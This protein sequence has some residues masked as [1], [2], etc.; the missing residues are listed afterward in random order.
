MLADLRF[1]LRALRRSP[2][3]VLAAVLCL[4]LGLR[5]ARGLAL[6]HGGELRAESVPGRGATFTLGVPAATVVPGGGQGGD[7]SGDGR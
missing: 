7:G 6:A 4:G 5:I 2:G 1:A 3:F